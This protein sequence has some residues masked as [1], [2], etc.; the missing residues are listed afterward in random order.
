[1]IS[2]RL[3]A[4]SYASFWRSLLPYCDAYVRDLNAHLVNEKRHA[5]DAQSTLAGV[6]AMAQQPSL[7]RAVVN[8]AGVRLYRSRCEALSAQVDD[9]E[10]AIAEAASWLGVFEPTVPAE[11]TQDVEFLVGRLV[12]SFGAT[13][14]S[15]V[16]GPRFAGC[17]LLAECEGDLLYDRDLVEVKSGDRAF[18]S[19]DVRQVL[20]YAALNRVMPKYEIVNVCI[21][22]ARLD[23]KVAMSVEEMCVRLGGGSAPDV[24]G[25]IADFAAAGVV[26]GV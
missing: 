24:L 19:V 21:Y 22:N 10:R 16:F 4:R 9:V 17:G 3:F 14:A 13:A 25:S 2:E 8:E 20:I 6:D 7:L 15:K 26:S 18:R 23:W 5:G 12:R 11:C 1:M